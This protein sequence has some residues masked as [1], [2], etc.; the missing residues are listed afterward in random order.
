[1]ANFGFVML[2]DSIYFQFIEAQIARVR[3]LDR[4]VEKSSNKIGIFSLSVERE[5]DCVADFGCK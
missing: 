1:M 5:E 4:V 3:I 2:L